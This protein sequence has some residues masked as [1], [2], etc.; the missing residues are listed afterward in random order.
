MR[1]SRS[2]LILTTRPMPADDHPSERSAVLA[3]RRDDA[4][5]ERVAAE[6]AMAGARSPDPV[7]RTVRRTRLGFVDRLGR[8]HTWPGLLRSLRPR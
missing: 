3:A 1:M 6:T 5:A 8:T 7:V 2:F 4:I